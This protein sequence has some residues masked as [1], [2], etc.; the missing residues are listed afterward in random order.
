MIPAFTSDMRRKLYYSDPA[1]GFTYI[2]MD[3][4]EELFKFQKD[5]E[6]RHKASQVNKTFKFPRKLE[7]KKPPVPESK[8]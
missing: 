5:I 2:N 7:V 3:I 6:S 8:H 1:K 4:E